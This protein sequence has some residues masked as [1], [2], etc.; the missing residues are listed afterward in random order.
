MADNARVLKKYPNR[1]LYDTH[2]S[3]YVTLEDVRQLILAKEAIKVLDSKTDE[4]ITRTVLLQ[5]IS[6]QEVE[7][8]EPILTNRVLEGLIRFYGQPG[9][10]ILGKYL[11][12]SLTTFL[13]Q[14]RR[15]QRQMQELLD[16]SPL[17]RVQKMAE[18][19]ANFWRGMFQAMTPDADAPA[20]HPPRPAENSKD[21]DSTP[22]SAPESAS[23]KDHKD[24]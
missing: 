18:Q 8:H 13:D 21:P 5:I 17:K 4:D 1:R 3:V 12:Q 7:G 15:Y 14:Q 6:E 19:N 20:R 22:D 23:K 11:E 10:G 24:T 16:K 2:T 9:Q